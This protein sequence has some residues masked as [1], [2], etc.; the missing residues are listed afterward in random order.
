[1]TASPK[2]QRYKSIE[3]LP[4]PFCG[5]RPTLLPKEPERDGDAWGEVACTNRRCPAQPKVKDGCRVRDDRGHGAYLDAAIRRWNR[6]VP[7]YDPRG[8]KW[9]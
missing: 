7:N 2:G 9:F 5:H 1:M 3:P 6:R 8:A 4:C